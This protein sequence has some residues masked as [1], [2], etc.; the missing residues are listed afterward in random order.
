MIDITN[1]NKSVKEL[2]AEMVERVLLNLHTHVVN[3]D[4]FSQQENDEVQEELSA[5]L[6]EKC[7]NRKYFPVHIF[8]YPD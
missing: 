4:P 3:I 6:C 1:R 8:L 2:F 5:T 7:P